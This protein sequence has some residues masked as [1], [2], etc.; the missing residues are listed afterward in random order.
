[1]STLLTLFVIPSAYVI[2]NRGGERLKNW[3]TG[4]PRRREV[5]MEPGTAAAGD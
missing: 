2:F 1:M 5:G 3:V 4:E